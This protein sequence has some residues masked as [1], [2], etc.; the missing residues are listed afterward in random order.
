VAK[1]IRGKGEKTDFTDKLMAL[2]N[3]ISSSLG[4][5]VVPK[6]GTRDAMEARKA[7][8]EKRNSPKA[9]TARTKY[10]RG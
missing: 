7:S 1:A 5:P 2:P 10:G 9:K 3:A 4:G 8:I 6:R